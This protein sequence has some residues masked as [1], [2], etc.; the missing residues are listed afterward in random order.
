MSKPRLSFSTP[1]ALG[2]VPDYLLNSNPL[3]LLISNHWRDTWGCTFGVRQHP[4]AAEVL[5]VTYGEVTFHSQFGAPP[6]K[7]VV[8]FVEVRLRLGYVSLKAGDV[9]ALNTTV[10]Q[11]GE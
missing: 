8:Q 11:L 7:A 9:L 3:D 5:D 4:G 6:L 2:L 1:A 10:H